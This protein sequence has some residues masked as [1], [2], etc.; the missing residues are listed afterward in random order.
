VVCLLNVSQAENY[1]ISIIDCSSIQIQGE[2]QTGER[3]VS[4]EYVFL[5][6]LVNPPPIKRADGSLLV[7]GVEM[8][9]VLDSRRDSPTVESGSTVELS[10]FSHL[11]DSSDIPVS[12]HLVGEDKSRSVPCPAAKNGSMEC[13]PVRGRNWQ[14]CRNKTAPHNCALVMH[15]FNESDSGNFSCSTSIGGNE[16]LS[17]VLQLQSMEAVE[18]IKKSKSR[19]YYWLIVGLGVGSAALLVILGVII[20]V[21]SV[22]R[23]R[24]K[25][26]RD[27]YQRLLNQDPN[28]G[29]NTPEASPNLGNTDVEA[30]SVTVVADMSS[31]AADDSPDPTAGNPQTTPAGGNL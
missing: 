26:S 12:F 7:R 11:N 4:F 17:N 24:R 9:I 20:I 10:C 6:N 16:V 3:E 13:S 8:E 29:I 14:V 15:N 25:A 22:V 2:V 23:S 5:C 30:S 1:N 31:G 27:R 18:P 21:V 28:E 19:S